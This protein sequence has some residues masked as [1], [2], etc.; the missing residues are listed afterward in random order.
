MYVGQAAYIFFIIPN[1]VDGADTF[2]KLIF[3]LDGESVWTYSHEPGNTTEFVY[4]AL[5]VKSE[6]KLDG[7]SVWTY[8]HEPGNTTEFVYNALVYSNDKIQPGHHSLM[9][10]MAGP[11]PALSL[12]DRM[13]YT[14][15]LLQSLL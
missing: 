10:V 6:N 12:F 2:V 7:E 8:S 14:F 9:I 5:P 1:H 15:V 11:K 4:N 3:T 13:I